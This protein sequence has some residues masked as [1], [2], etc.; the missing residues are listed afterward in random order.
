MLKHH[1]LK[2]EPDSVLTSGRARR[3]SEAGTTPS[4]RVDILDS[5]QLL[6]ESGTPKAFMNSSPGLRA[7]SALP[8]GNGDVVPPNPERVFELVIDSPQFAGVDCELFQSSG[9]ST[10][11]FPRVLP[12]AVIRERLQRLSYALAESSILSPLKRFPLKKEFVTPG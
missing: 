7:S 6:L 5:A 11:T 9:I 4:K 8:W 1:E 3:T 10:S 2:R 12:G